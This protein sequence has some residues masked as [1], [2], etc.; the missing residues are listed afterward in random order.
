MPIFVAYQDPS[1]P[2]NIAN[3][4]GNQRQAQ[5][6]FGNQLQG[7]EFNRQLQNDAFQREL[8]QE[9]EQSQ[10]EQEAFQRDQAQQA[11]ALRQQQVSQTGQHYND[12]IDLGYDKMDNNLDVAA[13]H[14]RA[15]TNRFQAGDADKLDRLKFEYVKR[16]DLQTAAALDKKAAQARLFE[17][18]GALQQNQFDSASQRQISGQDFTAFQK[19]LDRQSK[20]DR[21]SNLSAAAQLRAQAAV[22][23]DQD[24]RDAMNAK[25]DNEEAVAAEKAYYHHRPLDPT[26]ALVN[27]DQATAWA[28]EHEALRKIATAARTK[29]V[30]SQRRLS[31]PRD[32][33]QPALP[34]DA[35]TAP[36]PPQGPA[37]GV[38]LP[39]Q[40]GPPTESLNLNDIS[41]LPSGIH[42]A[43]G[44]NVT[45][46]E[47]GA[48]NYPDTLVHRDGSVWT[49]IGV[50]DQGKAIYRKETP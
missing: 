43:D 7:S 13:L 36:I 3:Q 25:A 49:F 45:P 16:G 46:A 14:E 21:D 50:D 8:A 24:T 4:V 19:A 23:K 15:K 38:G 29:A 34:P 32:Q 26:T 22:A 11:M 12:Q 20:A 31:L 39:G 33:R 42:T 30:D 47:G 48:A 17:Q 41:S 9:H 37:G 5:A 18:Q 44:D 28:T 35:V 1:I 10:R 40:A 2:L 6:N 27:P